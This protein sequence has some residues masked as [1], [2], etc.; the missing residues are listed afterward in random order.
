M[1]Q[2]TYDTGNRLKTATNISGSS[3]FTY[4]YDADGNVTAGADAGTLAYNADNQITT[5]GYAYDG[6]GKLTADP[7]SGTLAYND[8]GQMTSASNAG[9]NGPETFAYA[10]DTQDQVLS[11]GTATGITYGLNGQDGQPWIQSYSGN[12]IIH[13]Q[14]GTPLGVVSAGQASAYITDNNGSITAIISS[15]GATAGSALT[16]DPYGKATVSGTQLG[17][18]IGYTG[19]L[20]DTGF[21]D[22]DGIPETGYIHDGDRW[23]NPQ[24][25]TFTTTDPVTLLDNPASAN[26]Y[27]Y[28]ADNPANYIDPT[29][30]DDCMAA[31]ISGAA[32][33]FTG[34]LLA[35]LITSGPTAGLSVPAGILGGTLTG[36]IT[37]GVGCLVANLF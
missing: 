29:G 32:A 28:A 36:G 22:S 16:Y 30:Q 26:P 20:T 13:D 6:A 15:A 3:T 25:S 37:A 34:G 19:A 10:G 21:F 9:G 18:Q 5:S 14:Q 1:S 11:D 23:Y 8:A 24:T 12:Y 17:N 27:P 33:G 7:A 4:G 35:G 2:Y 31:I